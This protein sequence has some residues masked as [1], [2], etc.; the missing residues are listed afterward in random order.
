MRGERRGRSALLS[1]SSVPSEVSF[2][3]GSTFS[4]WTG[5]VSDVCVLCI[6]SSTLALATEKASWQ[7]PVGFL[8]KRG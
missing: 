6:L 4:L 2:E 5:S 7:E 1:T 8:S 3:R